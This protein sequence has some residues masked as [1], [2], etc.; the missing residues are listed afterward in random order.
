MS[1]YRR[2]LNFIFLTLAVL[3]SSVF[4]FQEQAYAEDLTTVLQVRSTQDEHIVPQTIPEVIQDLESKNIAIAR[5]LEVEQQTAED[6]AKQL[7]EKKAEAEYEKQRLEA[8][9]NMF[10]HINLY[11]FDAVG[12]RYAPGNCTWY[13]KNR[14]PDISNSWGNA[15]TWYYSAM[16][17]GWDVGITPKKGAV[18]TTTAGW[19]GHVAYVE[20]VS[21]DGLWVTVSEM[22]YGFLYNMN[23]RT[24]YYTE[25]NYIYNLD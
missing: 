23:R 7:A 25:F 21:V 3:S 20:G 9:K 5:Q 17:Q 4:L 14:R 16:S 13:V 2:F 11:A 15:N 24:V 22:N 10:V 1:K 18:A 12:N 6:L 19:A 8:I